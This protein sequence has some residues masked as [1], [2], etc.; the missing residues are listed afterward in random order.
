MNNDVKVLTLVLVRQAD[1]LLL[2][3]KKR[4]FGQGK[5][6]GFGGKV[7]PG[8]TIEQAA[9]REFSEETG[10]EVG[11]LRSCGHLTFTFA[12]GWPEMDVHVFATE[13]INGRLSETEEMLPH[14]FN[15]NA[16][17]FKE[18]WADNVHWLPLYLAGKRFA[19]SFHYLDDKTILHQSLIVIADTWLSSAVSAANQPAQLKKINKQQVVKSKSI[20]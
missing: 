12:N 8:E 18:M 3:R 2:G 19:G 13:R 9:K 7:E 20:H 17:P 6:N 14:W 4:G 15:I 10:A 16:L 1:R 11:D 5:W